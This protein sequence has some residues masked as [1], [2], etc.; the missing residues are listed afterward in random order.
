ML[1]SNP[2]SK[3]LYQTSASWKG[4]FLPGVSPST[5]SF[6]SSRISRRQRSF[7]VFSGV[8]A[9]QTTRA[10]S[11]MAANTQFEKTPA[12]RTDHHHLHLQWSLQSDTTPSNTF[13]IT[14]PHHL[15]FTITFIPHRIINR[16]LHSREV[17]EH[18]MVFRGLLMDVRRPRPL[19]VTEFSFYEDWLWHHLLHLHLTLTILHTSLFIFLF[20]YCITITNTK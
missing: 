5:Q 6:S 2:D 7:S 3:S 8:S 16:R 20:I 17:K 12:I 15:H 9:P 18:R 19:L 1:E 10:I 13:T 14:S 4:V 11:N